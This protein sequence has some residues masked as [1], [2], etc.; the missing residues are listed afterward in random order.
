MKQARD[1][2]TRLSLPQR[3]ALRLIYKNTRIHRDNLIQLMMEVGF[4]KSPPDEIDR[5]SNL[6]GLI[7][8]EFGGDFL[9]NAAFIEDVDQLLHA[10]L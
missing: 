1:Y 5:L 4:G 8:Y 9:I 7:T 6:N 10:G 3:Y 2:F